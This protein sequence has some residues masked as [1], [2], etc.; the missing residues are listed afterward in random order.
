M[1]HHSITNFAP[2]NLE[3]LTLNPPAARSIATKA[4]MKKATITAI[5][6]AILLIGT[7]SYFAYLSYS[8]KN[9][10]SASSSDSIAA[11]TKNY[12]DFSSGKIGYVKYEQRKAELR[13]DDKSISDSERLAGIEYQLT[14]LR[15]AAEERAR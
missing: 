3:T 7:W 15:I 11:I 8:A 13:R 6:F 10:A 9:R 4:A 12:D 14:L 5:I 1:L 2:K